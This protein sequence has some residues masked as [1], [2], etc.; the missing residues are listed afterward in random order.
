MARKGYGIDN[1]IVLKYA[2][3]KKIF[4][5]E[6]GKK[7]EGFGGLETAA[8]LP[9]PAGGREIPPGQHRDAE[10]QGGVAAFRLPAGQGVRENESTRRGPAGAR[11]VNFACWQLLR[12]D[13][14]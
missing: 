2:D 12:R 9:C 5:R 4:C 6:F 1:D 7:R 11:V 8:P 10:T 14:A 13:G 3:F